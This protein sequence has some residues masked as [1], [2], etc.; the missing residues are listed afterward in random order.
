[1]GGRLVRHLYVQSSI[2]IAYLETLVQFTIFLLMLLSMFF[3]SM[4]NI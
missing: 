2:K 3:E 4:M 1:M